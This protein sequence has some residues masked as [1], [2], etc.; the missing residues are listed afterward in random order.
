MRP[1]EASSDQSRQTASGQLLDRALTR[2]LAADVAQE[3]RLAF[4]RSLTFVAAASYAA[5]LYPTTAPLPLPDELRLTPLP[6]QANRI[7]TEL[8]AG[9]AGIPPAEAASLLGAIYTSTLPADFRAAHGVFYTPPEIVRLTLDMAERA[10]VNWRTARCLDPSAGGGAFLIGM[11]RRLRMALSGTE[12]ALLLRRIA[13]QVRGYDLDP[14]GAWLAQTVA[15]FAVHDLER[16]AG[17]S[18]PCIV[19]VRDSLDI[20]AEDHGAFNLVASNVPFGRISLPP[21]RRARYAR[22][23]YGHANLYALFTDA[24]LCYAA[25]DGVVAYVMPTS[26]LSGLYFRALRSLLAREAPPHELSLITERS[27]VFDD[28]L[29]ETMLA[30]WRKG[31]RA[32]TGA[33]HFVT[34]DS[35]G[36]ASLTHAGRLTLPSV[37]TAPWILPR[38]P[39]QAALAVHLR[40]MPC[41]L[42]DYG[43]VVSTGPLVWN[44]H[45]Q[46]FRA[47]PEAD[48][49]P[50]VWA[51]AVTADGRFAWRA[52]KRNHAPWF[53]PRFPKDDWLIVRRPCVLL[54]RTTA[55]EQ[56]RRL[57][58][59]EMP[60]DFLARHAG[61]VIV[62]NHLNMIY[63]RPASP[64]VS[65][66]V[67][68]AVLNSGAAD[69]AFRCISGSVAV[70]AFELEELPLP[71]PGT[72]GRVAAL[73]A[74]RAPAA[75]IEETIAAAYGMTD[76]AAAA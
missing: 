64:S 36:Q 16:I 14:F 6:P 45:K 52:E 4:A 65:P 49:L 19:H 15:R 18:L 9:L 24:A 63:S 59:A 17:R 41:R 10:G 60:A 29:Q 61:G 30:T 53:A 68:T 73:L 75:T 46:Q 44:R 66:A 38:R 3:H 11:I 22:S 1:A 54:Q 43:Y 21:D 51:E 31:R 2:A 13:S 76:A 40:T 42:S 56:H 39:E 12:P 57:I 62:E 69:A 32:K 34:I 26:M 72:L 23:T 50:V 70:S 5:S 20:P 74:R 71:P 58:A 55:K 28:A 27:G 67:I 8:G 7:A 25:A 37:P 47:Q 48:C 35:G 33:V